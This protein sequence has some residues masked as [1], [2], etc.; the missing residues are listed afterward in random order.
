MSQL[1]YEKSQSSEESQSS[2]KF[3]LKNL[4]LFGTFLSSI[5]SLLTIVFVAYQTKN[6]N[7]TLAEM[8]IASLL[9]THD[10]VHKHKQR[11]NEILIDAESEKVAQEVFN[12]NKS[13][14]V[15][16]ILINDYGGLFNLRCKEIIDKSTW[17]EIER[18]MYTS[19]HDND[20]LRNFW[21]NETMITNAKFKNYIDNLTSQDA[22]GKY[23]QESKFCSL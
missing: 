8:R 12:L 13:Q 18:I 6:M 22:G 16:Y 10:I 5:V 15:G 1:I 11:I 9:D 20:Y 4:E 17:N 3:S 21:K 7:E 23:G 19:L 14:L 2:G